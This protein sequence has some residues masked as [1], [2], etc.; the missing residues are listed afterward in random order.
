MSAFEETN[1]YQKVLL[2]L[3]YLL[4]PIKRS[5]SNTLMIRLGDQGCPM[6]RRYAANLF[7]CGVSVPLDL[8]RGMDLLMECVK[9][10]DEKALRDLRHWEQKL[11]EIESLIDSADYESVSALLNGRRLNF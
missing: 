6:P 1:L 4:I 10:G 9:S 11:P 7:L 3:A 2:T 8:N 5:W